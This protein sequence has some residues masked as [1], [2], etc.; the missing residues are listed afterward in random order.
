[1]T[2]RFGPLPTVG[3]QNIMTFRQC[4][5]G[6]DIYGSSTDDNDAPN[7]KGVPVDAADF[8][9]EPLHKALG[10]NAAVDEFFTLMAVCHTVRAEQD[11]A[12]VWQYNAE[13]PD[14]KALVDSAR[15]AGFVFT[16]NLGGIST[17]EDRSNPAQIKVLK[18]E[19]LETIEFDSTRKRMSI[20]CKNSAGDRGV[21]KG[22]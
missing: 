1:M 2:D 17:I 22:G 6:G 9:D 12:G 14:E 11:D 16:Q 7:R 3:S 20:I 5:I 21:F 19:V 15:D 4:S 13:S 8:I 10:D 18:Y